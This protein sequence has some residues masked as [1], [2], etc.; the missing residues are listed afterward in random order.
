MKR[1]FAFAA[2]LG[3]A[4][5]LAAAQVAKPASDPWASVRFLIGQWE[6]VGSGAPGQASGG[7]AFALELNANILV[8]KNWSNFPPKPGET[9]GLNHEDLMIVYPSGE[10]AGLRAIYFDMEGHVIQY[11]L[12]IPASPNAAVFESDAAQKGP[13]YR[14]TYS[15][16]ADGTLKNTFSIAMPGQDFKEYMTGSLKK[17]S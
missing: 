15:L 13:R 4:A 2:V 16:A 10:A 8:R 14:L 9:K 17:K 6:G 1:I 5:G 12:V 3:I 7:T 11:T